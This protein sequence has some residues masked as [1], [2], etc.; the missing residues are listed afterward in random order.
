MNKIFLFST[1]GSRKDS[2]QPIWIDSNKSSR[3][4]I[5]ISILRGYY[6]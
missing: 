6:Y 3:S 1:T 2:M 4:E 5:F